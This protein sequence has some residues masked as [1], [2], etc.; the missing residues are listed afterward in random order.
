MKTV[1]KKATP[2]KTTKAVKKAA[3][4]RIKNRKDGK[5]TKEQQLHPAVDDTDPE[6]EKAL[7]AYFADKDDHGE[8][9]RELTAHKQSVLALIKDKKLKRYW[10]KKLDRGVELQ[11]EGEKLAEMKHPDAKKKGKKQSAATD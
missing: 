10:S 7:R 1:T 9:T 4:S 6:L 5:A 3:S 2:R 11:P 8:L